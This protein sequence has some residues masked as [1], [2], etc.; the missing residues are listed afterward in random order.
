MLI[1]RNSILHVVRRY[2]YKCR[3]YTI[4]SPD[5]IQLYTGHEPSHPPTVY[6]S[7]DSLAHGARWGTVDGHV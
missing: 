7:H 4:P 2:S 6:A 5:C 1:S 3:S